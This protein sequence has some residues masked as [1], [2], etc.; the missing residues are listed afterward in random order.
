MDC[1]RCVPTPIPLK[2]VVDDA[3][4]LTSTDEQ[5]A[6]A[7]KAELKRMADVLEDGEAFW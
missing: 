4:K 5:I 6:T 1:V 2:K 3:K 7:I